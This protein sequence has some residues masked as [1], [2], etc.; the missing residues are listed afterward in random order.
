[1]V[2]DKGE[3]QLTRVNPVE[4]SIADSAPRLVGALRLDAVPFLDHA[5]EALG[6]F[7]TLE[8]PEP[9]RHRRDGDQHRLI[10]GRQLSRADGITA[11]SVTVRRSPTYAGPFRMSRQERRRSRLRM[12]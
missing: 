9:Q 8:A 11:F 7:H 6:L 12:R 1:M 4:D 5:V 3:R 10:E 2:H